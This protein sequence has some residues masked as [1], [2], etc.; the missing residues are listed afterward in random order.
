MM[1]L[2]YSEEELARIIQDVQV[3][4]FPRRVR[5]REFFLDFDPL[6][7]GRC[8]VPHFH[9]GLD[10]AGVSLTEREIEILSDHF[11]E[12]GGRVQR[13]QVV[14]YA[15]FC[16]AIDEVFNNGDP[17]QRMTSSPSTTQMMSQSFHR[18]TVEDEERMLNLLHRVAMLCKTRGVV[19]KYCY[20][21]HD[22]API[23]SPSRV[24]PKTGGKVTK[25]QFIRNF[26]FKKDLS[27][28]DLNMLAERYRVGGPE[29]TSAG[30]VHFMA[31][32]NDISEAMTHEMPP[33][34]R[35]D[36]FLKPDDTEWS[37]QRL[38]PVQ[39]IQSKVVERRV[40][41]YEHFQDF[42]PLRKGV[43]TVGQVKTVFT[44]M[45]VA[46]EIDRVEF[47]TVAAAY[48]RDDGLFCYKDFCADIDRGFATPNLEKDPMAMTT[49]PDATSTAP[50][51]RNRITMTPSR[52]QQ[53]MHLEDKLRSRIRKRGIFMK[54]AFQ[55]MDRTNNGHVTRNQFSRVM[56]MC[57][58]ELDEV[59]IGLLCGAYCDLGNHNDF[60][61]IDFLKSVCPPDGDTELAMEQ[62]TG[63]HQEAQCSKYFDARGTVRPLDRVGSPLMA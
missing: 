6:R 59:N 55:D 16:M 5:L 9:R 60:N 51:R 25:N 33:F 56:H 15:K 18:N 46:K 4:V 10:M 2:H 37:H 19:L 39:K 62:A 12:S 1:S 22:R 42:D 30:D 21:D 58:F 45:G 20:T 28:V 57:G 24:N 3:F 40:R 8:T 47:D 7:S 32:H 29:G 17:N 63:P 41:L 14:N 34:P 52:I 31:L 61:Y 35:S 54:P 48:L 23:A 26:P 13:P 43:C 49:M 53:V 44:M 11:T 50:G 36:L 27:D 38:H